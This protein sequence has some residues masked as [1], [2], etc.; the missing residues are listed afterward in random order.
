MRTRKA[1]LRRWHFSGN[2]D[3]CEGASRAES[4]LEEF[5]GGAHGR[6]KALQQALPAL[7][8]AMAETLSPERGVEG[9]TG[10]ET[11]GRSGSDLRL[12]SPWFPCIPSAAEA[13]GNVRADLCFVT[14]AL[15]AT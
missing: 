5:L 6:A 1:P 2:L 9:E 11:R 4:W 15:P 7:P 8:H 14:V 12:A 3:R 10:K 13:T